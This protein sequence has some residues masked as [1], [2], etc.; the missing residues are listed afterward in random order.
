[1][2][3]SIHGNCK[4]MPIYEFVCEKCGSTLEKIQE[5]GSQPPVH[6]GVGM[7]MR[8]SRPAM[9]K[10]K[11]ESGYSIH[12]KGYKDGYKKEYLKSKGQEEWQGAIIN[13]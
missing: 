7:I 10:M 9:V 3:H 13:P 4:L 12:S 8:R 2:P 11:N 1:M 6:C 5:I